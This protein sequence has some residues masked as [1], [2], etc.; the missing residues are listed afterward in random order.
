MFT[1]T[2]Y[3]KTLSNALEVR[4]RTDSVN[5]KITY[6]AEVQSVLR[7]LLTESSSHRMELV[8]I[9]LI[10]VEVVIVGPLNSDFRVN[11][12]VSRNRPL[13]E[14]DLNSGICWSAQIQIPRRIRTSTNQSPY[15]SRTLI[16][17]KL[18]FLHHLDTTLRTT[19]LKSVS[20]PSHLMIY[21]LPSV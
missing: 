11:C 21:Y 12:L 18:I 14:M 17:S 15:C 6:A 13:F 3:F 1:V 8:I 10:A 20:I 9:A 2:G 16:D 7:S 4:S 19:L 5:E